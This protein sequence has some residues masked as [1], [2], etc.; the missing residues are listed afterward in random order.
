MVGEGAGPHGTRAAFGLGQS[1]TPS[2]NPIEFR[3]ALLGTCAALSLGFFA[4][5]T[6][7]RAQEVLNWEASGHFQFNLHEVSLALDATGHRAVTVRFSVTDPMNGGQAWDLQAAPEWKQ[8]A[9]ASRLSVDL[10]WTTS[11]YQNTGAANEAL[12]PVPFKT[13]GGV[14]SGGGAGVAPALPVMVDALRNA[15]PVGAAHP[16]WYE[17]TGV[18]PQQAS[19]SGVA[20]LEGHPAWPTVAT[21]GTTVWER[22]PVTSAHRFFAVTDA[23]PVARRQ[24]VQISK[25]QQ[26]HDGNIHGSVEIPRLSL[27]GGNRTENLDVCVTCHNPN[28]T[29][30]GYRTSGDETPVDFKYMVHAI[31]AAKRRH[32]PL[33]IIGFR[34]STNDFSDVRF[35]SKLSNCVL[36][37]VDNGR[38]GTFELP[39]AASVQGTTLHTQSVPGGFVDVDPANDTKMSPTVSVCSACHDSD[40]ALSHMMS[41]RTGGSFSASPA[42]L[43]NG[44]VVERCVNCHGTGKDKDLRHVHEIKSVASVRSGRSS[45]IR[46]SVVGDDE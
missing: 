28:Q 1:T 16:G 12:A 15:K 27:H 8:P 44:R 32:D 26:C 30:I 4:Q 5:T 18:L 39:L 34:G 22:V 21:D 46:D 43:A 31:H 23:A 40:E 36:C 17:V 2:M 33:V 25:C 13:V 41:R 7:V 29:D 3:R 14:S 42:D 9:G 37:H 35:P 20:L 10:G 11:E 38:K 19:R 24:V 45:A 6:V